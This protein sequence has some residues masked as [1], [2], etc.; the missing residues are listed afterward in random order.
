MTTT[1]EPNK[2]LFSDFEPPTADDWLAAATDAQK[3]APFDRLRTQTP[4]GLTLE[5][6]YN[7]GDADHLPHLNTFPGFT[8]YVRGTTPLTT[9]SAGWLAAQQLPYATP[10]ELNNALR[11]DLSRGQN[12]VYIV[13]DAVTARGADPDGN[14]VKVDEIGGDGTSIATVSDFRRI[15]SEVDA[16]NL[17][18][19]L[20]T[21]GAVTALPVL[22]IAALEN[23]PI[24]GALLN[25]P[26]GYLM[27]TGTL[28]ASVDDYMDQMATL[29]R[30]TKDNQPDLRTIA[31]STQTMQNAGANAVQEIGVALAT[32]VYYIR[33]LLERGLTINAIATQMTVSM[34]TGANFFMEVAKLRAMRLLWAQVIKAFGGDTDAQKIHLHTQNARIN[35]TQ[36]DPYVNMLRVTLETL[37]GAI[38]QADSIHADAFD[39][40]H[41]KPDEF[42]R[43]IARNLHTI[44]QEEA[45][46]NRVVDP[47]GG[48]Y[49][50]EYLT[51]Q[52]ARE[53]WRYFQTIEETGG[54][55][56]ALRAGQIQSDVE[57]IRQARTDALAQR[58]DVLV[59]T[60]QYANPTEST[61]PVSE[62]NPSLIAEKRRATVNAFRQDH[63]GDRKNHPEIRAAGDIE[64]MI[65]SARVGATLGDLQRAILQG[66][67]P[68]TVTP[69][70]TTRLAEPF[71]Q[72]RATAKH[73]HQQN[74]HPPR[75]YCANVG[76]L[77]THKARTDFT[78]GFFEVGGFDVLADDSHTD[79][80]SAATAALSSGA[81]IVVIC[82]TDAIYQDAVPVIAGR[83]K[84]EKP[85]TIVVLAG[86][87]ADKITVY[88]SAG[89]DEFIHLRANCAAMNASLL[90]RIGAKA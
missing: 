34:A 13:I 86:H 81:P 47:V 14:D 41:D 54:I 22:L 88:Q 61:L 6:I 5:P 67:A 78:V 16:D 44:L 33:A 1:N 51:D 7:A 59:G 72:L 53:S 64:G 45:Y 62:Q 74:G 29:A 26:I 28:P 73:Y 8:P 17:P 31:V 30:W 27:T 3:G 63:A 37:A 80:D 11:N 89:V 40:L 25:D 68:L 69:L 90:E 23:K 79:A 2:R 75:I 46:I 84:A 24:H 77:A 39:V 9:R 32:A 76:T 36:H 70:T 55:L 48:S 38:G 4:E 87:P 58:R 82:S 71:E 42:S 21:G 65:Q 18:I 49:Y 12:A 52:L 66:Q 43:R 10:T 20:E 83:I 50:V 56:D 60:N 85:E 35:L 19:I 15:F 57:P